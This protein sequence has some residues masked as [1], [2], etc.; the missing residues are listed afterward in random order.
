MARCSAKLD[1]V[2]VV[3][4]LALMAAADV[5]TSF[6]QPPAQGARAD[7]ARDSQA[8]AA[9]ESSAPS[10]RVDEADIT[11]RALLTRA[12]QQFAQRQ[13]DEAVAAWERAMDGDG[14]RLV[15]I[16]DRH[17]RQVDVADDSP[18]LAIVHY[19]TV[20]HRAQQWLAALHRAHP[21]SL[22]AFRRRIDVLAEPAYQAAIEQ[23]DFERLEQIVDQWFLSGVADDA[24][25]RLGDEALREGRYVAARR[26][27]ERIHPGLRNFGAPAPPPG[28]EGVAPPERREP[29]AQPLRTSRSSELGESWWWSVGAREVAA[30]ETTG[31]A[32]TARRAINGRRLPS[33][34]QGPSDAEQESPA[35]GARLADRVD[36][37]AN[38]AGQSHG[39]A[40]NR[41]RRR[42]LPLVPDTQPLEVAARASEIQRVTAEE[43]ADSVVPTGPLGSWLA[44]P[45]SDIPMADVAARLVLVSIQEGDLARAE[46]ELAG[47]RA[48]H[49]EAPGELAGRR[50]PW[51][52]LL[53]DW[54]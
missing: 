51:V 34:D 8:S 54:L 39:G 33:P 32:P 2:A 20:R 16:V 42:S 38:T 22:A 28:G 1:S 15:P 50:E 13:W 48:R 4:L 40:A 45:D 19:V 12:E 43:P 14:D 10:I 7:R 24:L 5:R 9:R 17:S 11:T 25:L 29:L 18:S 53:D 35:S 37:L 46:W 47:F 30:R 26:A 52:K 27:W 36:L 21:P 3:F 6:A 31:P 44:Y 49:G 23:G 41:S